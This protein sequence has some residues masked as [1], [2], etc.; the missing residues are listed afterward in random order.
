LAPLCEVRVFSRR[1]RFAG[2]LDV[3]GLWRG[4]GALIDYKTG[5][6]RDVAAD[7]QTA[8]YYG[9]LLEMIEN[10]DTPDEVDFDP[11]PHRYSVGGT[12]WPSVTQILQHSGLIDFSHVPR[13][14]LDAARE[15]GDAVHRAAHYFNEGDLDVADFEASF[16]TYWP[17]L[18]SW[19]SFRR[20]S[21]FVLAT[22]FEELGSLSHVKRFAVQL[23]KA[24]VPKV[25]PYTSPRDYRE[26]LALLTAQQIVASRRG[27]WSE[28]AA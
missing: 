15:R 1:H 25:E 24:G 21:G 6:P 20:D 8:A 2:T 28:A 27:E 9:A 13:A 26:F 3:L 12:V 23:T 4:A 11:V 14:T 22:S 16:P 5:S 17:Y 7:L 19:I 10:G 18:S